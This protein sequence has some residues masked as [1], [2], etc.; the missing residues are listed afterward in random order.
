MSWWHIGVNQVGSLVLEHNPIRFTRG[1]F[2]SCNHTK[3]VNSPE[4]LLSPFSWKKEE[5]RDVSHWNKKKILHLFVALALLEAKHTTWHQVYGNQ[6][7]TWIDFWVKVMRD[8]LRVSDDTWFSSAVKQ[9]LGSCAW[10][11]SSGKTRR[12][13]FTEIQH[14]S[15][16]FDLLIYKSTREDAVRSVFTTDYCINVRRLFSF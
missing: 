7:S 15:K 16:I 9:L 1:P 2:L 11:S 10:R 5:K 8:W 14:R 3:Y 4:Q 12:R 6:F 13:P